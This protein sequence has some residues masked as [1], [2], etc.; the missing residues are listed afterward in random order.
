M[1]GSR[2][3]PTGSSGLSQPGCD[4]TLWHL[5]SRAARG[6]AHAK[7][8]MP[9]AHRAGRRKEEEQR[10]R[11][12]SGSSSTSTS[13][14]SSSSGRRGAGAGAHLVGGLVGQ[15]RHVGHKGSVEWDAHGRAAQR[16]PLHV[17]V[18]LA[19]QRD[20]LA[21]GR[22]LLHVVVVAAAAKTGRKGGGMWSGGEARAAGQGPGCGHRTRGEA[23][24]STAGR[25]PGPWAMQHGEGRGG[26]QAREHSRIGAE[27]CDAKVGRHLDPAGEA[28]SE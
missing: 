23:S 18:G 1:H 26:A 27:A 25:Q 13:S 24:G 6:K 22:L 9:V 5:A 4:G 17:Q 21:A 12:S 15:R 20:G 10:R 3:R 2:R 11:S 16:P 14:R 19:D 8:R 28:G 7:S